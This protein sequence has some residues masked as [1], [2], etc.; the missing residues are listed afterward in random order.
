MK[1]NFIFILILTS[2]SI[3]AWSK[4]IKLAYGGQVNLDLKEWEVVD[5]K[6]MVEN[7]PQSFVHKKHSDLKGWLFGGM[8]DSIAKCPKPSKSSF[9]VCSESMEKDNLIHYQIILT[10]E[11]DKKSFQN[12]L[13]SFSFSKNEKLKYS[14]LVEAFITQIGSSKL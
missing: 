7:I 9:G 2:F 1:Q 12:Y 11:V 5:T 3:A 8:P 10:R 14:P 6:Q 4:P 13:I